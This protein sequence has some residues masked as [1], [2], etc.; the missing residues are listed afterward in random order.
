MAPDE[1][2]LEVRAPRPRLLV[3]AAAAVT[4][5]FG[6][7]VWAYAEY[8]TR[9]R[10]PELALALAILL[11]S[12]AVAI[13]TTFRGTFA[14]RSVQGARPL[15]AQS[16]DP[17]EMVPRSSRKSFLALLVAAASSLVAVV[18]LPLRSLGSRPREVLHATAWRRGVRLVTTDGTPLRLAD[19]P[20]GSATPVVPSSSRDDGNSAATLVRL[21][22]S[23][24]VHAYSRICTHAGCSVCVFRADRSLLVCPCHHST[25]DASNGGRILSGPASQ[26]L[27]ELPL[28]VDDDGWLVADGDFDRPIG[29]VVG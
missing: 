27:P 4:V 16:A 8:A 19:L 13:L 17:V 23:G 21:R 5:A 2:V 26:P 18:L 9:A 1:R 12:I 11:F 3:L 6:A 29:P 14:F 7:A 10:T 15:P 20:L 28:A 24:E 22:G 25:F